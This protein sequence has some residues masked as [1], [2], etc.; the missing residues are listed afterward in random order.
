MV[1][2]SGAD[3]GF[4]VEGAPTLQGG[5]VQ[6]MILPKISEK[7]HEIEKIL[8]PRRAISIATFTLHC[9]IKRQYFQLHPK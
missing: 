1:S 6:P 7:L 4:S 9:I 5:G 2:I 3:P 8:D